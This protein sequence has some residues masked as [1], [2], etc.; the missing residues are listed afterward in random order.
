MAGVCI[1]TS[2]YCSCESEDEILM[3]FLLLMLL[4]LSRFLSLGSKWH[5]FSKLILLKS[6]R[7]VRKSQ[8]RVATD[9]SYYTVRC[10]GTLD[11]SKHHHAMQSIASSLSRYW[12]QPLAGA[13]KEKHSLSPQFTSSHRRSEE[14][15]FSPCMVPILRK[16]GG[17]KEGSLVEER[18]A[19][20]PRSGGKEG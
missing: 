1:H 15:V 6:D 2:M 9:F 13:E 4:L 10:T 17:R 19:T 5:S 20:P 8:S 14:E 11:D 12:T 7:T 3:Q 18:L 16:E